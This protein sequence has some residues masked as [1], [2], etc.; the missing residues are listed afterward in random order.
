MF[1]LII[2]RYPLP[3]HLWVILALLIT[4][5]ILPVGRYTEIVQ[6]LD[7]RR[8]QLK[9]TIV[10]EINRVYTS[11][12]LILEHI[13]SVW[14]HWVHHCIYQVSLT[15]VY[16]FDYLIERPIPCENI[17]STSHA[18]FL[19]FTF[20]AVQRIGKNSDCKDKDGHQVIAELGIEENIIQFERSWVFQSLGLII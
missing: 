19:I 1:K 14:M 20:L 6:S 17:K 3:H 13:K 9:S 2:I 5:Q 4:Q 8:E 12:F 15:D 18:D 16:T 10:Q 11:S 7:C